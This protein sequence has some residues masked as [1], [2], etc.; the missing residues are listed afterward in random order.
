MY[1]PSSPPLT[2]PTVKTPG[3]SWKFDT[4]LARGCWITDAVPVCLAVLN[5]RK[6]VGL[7][8]CDCGWAGTVQ[9]KDSRSPRLTSPEEGS[10]DKTG[11]GREVST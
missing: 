5:K 2:G 3:C 9:L 11:G 8:D 6:L 1:S 10:T 4:W 7:F